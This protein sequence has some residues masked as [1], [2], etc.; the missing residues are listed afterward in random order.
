M[1][2][3]WP[4]NVC[5]SR[6]FLEIVGRGQRG[7]RSSRVAESHLN[8]PGQVASLCGQAEVVLLLVL[9]EATHLD[10]QGARCLELGAR[11]KE[12]GARS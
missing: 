11:S 8:V 4:T 3:P 6:T 5:F 1:Q 7:A 2:N 12:P 10:D 9:G